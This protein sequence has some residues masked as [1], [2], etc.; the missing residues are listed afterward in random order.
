MG[1]VREDIA[2]IIAALP[3]GTVGI[4]DPAWANK[5]LQQ[6]YPKAD[7]ILSLVCKR[8]EG[9]ELSEIPKFL[10]NE[11]YRECADEDGVIQKYKLPTHTQSFAEGAKAF[12][13]SILDVIKEE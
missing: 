8:I 3:K 11:Y 10:P 9:V 12:R 1:S 6:A 13:Q 7:Q 4:T 5:R 2:G